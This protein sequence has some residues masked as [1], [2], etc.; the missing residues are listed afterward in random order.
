M[1]MGINSSLTAYSEKLQYTEK[2]A[3]LALGSVALFDAWCVTAY[4]KTGPLML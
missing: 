2:V 3:F 1:W 4:I